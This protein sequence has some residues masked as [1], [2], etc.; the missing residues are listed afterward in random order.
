MEKKAL[1]KRSIQIINKDKALNST[2]GIGLTSK[3]SK[4]GH[5]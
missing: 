2:A 1:K 4:A 5:Y 3:L